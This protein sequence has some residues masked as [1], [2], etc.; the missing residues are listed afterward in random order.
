MLRNGVLKTDVSD[1][2]HDKLR[3]LLVED[4]ESD[5]YAVQRFL[6]TYM[7]RPHVII[8][9]STL[10]QAERELSLK[11]NH[12]DIVLLDLG[13]PDST[14]N[15]ETYSRISVYKEQ[16]PIIVLT[17]VDD[18]DLAIK[19]LGLG[20]QDYV[21]KDTVYRDPGNLCRNI[22]FSIER[23]RSVNASKKEM[24]MLIAEQTDLLQLV[25]GSYSVIHDNQ[26]S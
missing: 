26:H 10:E 16:F 6:E 15:L 17:S 25:T 1:Y 12:I 21:K 8:R 13:L 19:M 18:D 4:S 5:A 7:A 11:G 14:G 23:H 3:I 22:H 9:A 20:A 2:D 24:S